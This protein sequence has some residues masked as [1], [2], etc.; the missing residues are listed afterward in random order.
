M[1]ARACVWWGASAGTARRKSPPPGKLANL[2]GQS[3]RRRRLPQP[4]ALPGG[5]A[6]ASRAA[7]VGHD[8]AVAAPVTAAEERGGTG[9]ADTRPAL[10]VPSG[11]RRPGA[12]EGL[13]ERETCSSFGA[14]RFLCVSVPRLLE[15]G[16]RNA[17]IP[18]NCNG[19]LFLGGIYL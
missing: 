8:C 5:R 4:G 3:C 7:S 9:G 19:F 16:F 17:G 1:C 12:V 13:V 2:S 6:P 10:L 14:V 15:S 11:G 18:R